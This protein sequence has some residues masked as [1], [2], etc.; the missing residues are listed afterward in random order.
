MSTAIGITT[1]ALR[2]NGS[3]AI[4]PGNPG[5]AVTRN[6][7]ME[8]V[9]LAEPREGEVVV[10]PLYVGVCGSDVHAALG[11]ANFAWVERPRTI[12]HEF[13]GRIVEFG[14]HTSGWGGFQL[15]DIVTGM[16]QLGCRHVD[17]PG[18]QRGRW[19]Y[20]RKKRILGFHRDGAMAE[21]VVFEADRLVPLRP[22][23][24]PVQG[25]VIEP[26]SVVAQAIDSKCNIKP[27]MD[28]VVSGSG[29]IGLMAAELAR[30]AGG[31]VA[32][33]GLERDRNI[34]LKTAEERGFLPIV[35]SAER[36]LQQQLKEGVYDA[37]GVRFGC[38]YDDGT[39]D[40][41]IEC[42]GAPG[43]LGAAPYCVKTEGTICVIATYG[44]DVSFAA[45]TQVRGGLTVTGVMGSGRHDF[46]KAQRLLQDGTFPA[47]Y[48]SRIY[49]F[50]NAI[51]AFADSIN[52]LVPKAVLEVQKP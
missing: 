45:T 23:V 6:L 32:I 49:P 43:A 28:V 13:S 4:H 3:E 14:P 48:Y 33:T 20:C 41:L 7:G 35:V 46:E 17:C 21:R 36:T 12:G 34:R 26:L 51:E 52:A 29:I 1:A 5:G 40:V 15:G 18:C 22:G 25:A 16:P 8:V 11:A 38:A 39:V 31:R 24:T 9:P 30:A 44:S 10:E 19:N 37:R 50:G 2:L 47:D 27:G 42:S